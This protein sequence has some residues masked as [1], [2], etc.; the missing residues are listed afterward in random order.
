M[1]VLV[2]SIHGFDKSFLETAAEGKHELA[3][4]EKALNLDTVSL[5]TGFDSVAL[6]S[7]DDASA[8]VLEKLSQNGVKYITLRSVGYDHVDLKKANELGIKVANVPEYSPYAIAEHGVAMLLMLNRKLLEA[9][10]L[11]KKQD[12]RLDTLVG[13]DLHGKTVGIIG[14]GKIGFAF[15]HIMFGFGC[16][17]LAYDPV[18]NPKASSIGMKYTSLEELLE[19]SDVVSLN[20]PLNEHTHYLIDAPQL[21]LMK[22]HA[23]LINTARGGVVNTKALIHSLES[24]HLGGACLDV[25]EKEKGLFFYDHSNTIL[26]DDM[27]MHLRSFNNVLITGHQA[28]LTHEALK[29]IA[30]IS[31]HNLTCWENNLPCENELN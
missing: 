14:T 21:A 24:G 10:E 3:F 13:F 9:Q 6:F 2:Y 25:Y 12:F 29:G 8:E 20:C 4:T 23:I 22:P 1:K 31:L 11:I 5:S 26:N 16:K 27:Y 17:L 19:T 18:Q 28:F 15:A 30:D 7:N